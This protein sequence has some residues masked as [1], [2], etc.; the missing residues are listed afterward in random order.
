MKPYVDLKRKVYSM[1]DIYLSRVVI[2]LVKNEMHLSSH[3]KTN[4]FTFHFH[5]NHFCVIFSYML[6]WIENLIKMFLTMT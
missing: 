5:K 3:A 2:D 6:G 4:H 1:V